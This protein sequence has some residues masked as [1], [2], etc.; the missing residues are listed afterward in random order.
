MNLFRGK[1]FSVCVLLILFSFAFQIKAQNPKAKTP[2]AKKTSM[3]KVNDVSFPCPKRFK[4]ELNYNESGVFLAQNKKDNLS[5]FVVSSKD[6]AEKPTLTT[7]EIKV[8]LIVLFPSES[9]DYRW[10]EIDY[11]NEKLSSKFETGKKMLIGFNG[12]QL[13]TVD[14]R[15]ILVNKKNIFVG[16]ISVDAAKGKEAE[17][18]FNEISGGGNAG[19][20]ETFKIIQAITGEKDSDELDPCSIT[21]EAVRP[22]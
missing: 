17:R 15:H 18:Y 19:C 9:F 2:S 22:S 14:Y 13:I 20:V 6:T 4:V 5:L 21:I 1:K 10:R 7:D 16:S 12:N 8:L 3:C 11:L